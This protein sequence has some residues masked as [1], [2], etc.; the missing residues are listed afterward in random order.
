MKREKLLPLVGQGRVDLW[1]N[2]D[3]LTKV[4]FVVDVGEEYIFYYTEASPEHIAWCHLDRVHK[5]LWTEEVK[6]EIVSDG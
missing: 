5:I 1:V 4:R 6:H 3:V 2:S